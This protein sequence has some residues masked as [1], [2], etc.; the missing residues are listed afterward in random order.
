MDRT[1]DAGYPGCESPTLRMI[2]SVAE[3]TKE[4]RAIGRKSTVLPPVDR[5]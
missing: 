4:A 2:G 1:T 5:V 3:L